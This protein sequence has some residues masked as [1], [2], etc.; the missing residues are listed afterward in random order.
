MGVSVC[1]RVYVCFCL[2]LTLCVCV[3][4]P[5]T[6]SSSYPV[7]WMTV[8]L[9]PLVASHTWISPPRHELTTRGPS[10]A[11][12]STSYQQDA[13]VFCARISH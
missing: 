5:M 12:H 11:K 13:V 4:N 8:S 7:L 6:Y 1:V 9:S 2:L 10:T 3:I